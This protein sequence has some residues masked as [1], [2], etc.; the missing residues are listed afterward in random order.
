MSMSMDTWSK[1]GFVAQAVCGNP[2]VF[3]KP[4]I[5]ASDCV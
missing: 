1:Y 3:E 2:L 4:K 5:E